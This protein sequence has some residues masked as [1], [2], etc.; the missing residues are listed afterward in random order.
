MILF[1]TL[2]VLL[3]TSDGSV[4]AYAASWWS[5]DDIEKHLEK[6][7]QPI[8]SN[9]SDQ[10]LELFRQVCK[11]YR[12]NSSDLEK[13]VV[14]HSMLLFLLL[15]QGITIQVCFQVFWPARSFLGSTL[16]FFPGKETIDNHI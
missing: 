7:N 3:K 15:R 1:A 2:Q 14:F 16:C 4:L 12:G 11:V 5:S 13:Y 10:K 9:F 8:W 6:V